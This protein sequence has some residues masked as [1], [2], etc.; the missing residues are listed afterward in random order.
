MTKDCLRG[1]PTLGSQR[2]F[3]LVLAVQGCPTLLSNTLNLSSICQPCRINEYNTSHPTWR[4]D[5]SGGGFRL[6]GARGAAGTVGHTSIHGQSVMDEID[7]LYD[8]DFRRSGAR[9]EGSTSSMVATSTTRSASAQSEN[10]VIVL[11]DSD[12]DAP[13][14]PAKRTN[15]PAVPRV[16]LN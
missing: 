15:R 2:T 6:S 9:S 14:P 7:N 3:F 8:Q 10:D 16:L 4:Q 12:E 1:L 13:H 5:S 11:D